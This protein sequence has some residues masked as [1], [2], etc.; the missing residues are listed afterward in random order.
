MLLR[1][2]QID[3]SRFVNGSTCQNQMVLLRPE[4]E[5][6]VRW[7]SASGED[8]RATSHI[9]VAR[10]AVGAKQRKVL[11]HKA[12]ERFRCIVKIHVPI[13]RTHERILDRLVLPV[14]V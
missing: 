7:L 4:I 1:C 3:P 8:V 13:S 10:D 2:W 11:T 12:I 9:E 5:V 14:H 6:L